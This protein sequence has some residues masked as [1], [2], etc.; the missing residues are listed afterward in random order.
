MGLEVVVRPVVLPNIRPAPAQSLPPA[1]DPEKGF[2]EIKGNPAKEVSFSNS[3]QMSMSRSDSTET[4]RRVDETRTYQ[5][6]DDGT[7]NKDNF[8]DTDVANRIK[9]RGG[10]QPLI[11]G[12]ENITGSKVP[13]GDSTQIATWYARQIEQANIEIRKRDQIKKNQDAGDQ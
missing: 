1:D 9:A 11:D 4:E 10:K 13:K 5:E 8:V 3:R 7:V 6:N 2:C 12:S